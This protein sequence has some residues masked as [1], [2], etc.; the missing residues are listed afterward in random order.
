MNTS[1]PNLNPRLFKIASLLEPCRC[2][3][4]IGT[5]HGYIP[6]YAL[7]KGICKKAIASDINPGPLA[8]AKEHAK[9]TNLTDKLDLRL[10]GGLSTLK[11]GEA[12]TIVI[13]G[14]GGL[15]IAEI[16]DNSPEIVK[17]ASTL[18]LQPMTAQTELREYLSKGGYTL[19]KEYLVNEDE[20]IYNIFKVTVGGKTHYTPKELLLGKNVEADA[21]LVRLHFE[22]IERKLRIR[23]EGLENSAL[24]ES[25]S[26]A[27]EVRQLLGIINS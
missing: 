18:I 3:A 15:L 7:S 2:L 14:M 9:Q 10:G 21:D 20:K 16:L 8:R 1:L 6:I 11:E 23:L 25:K 26:K 5:D 13:A 27:E 19:E 24:E 17:G 22:K 4:D 12:D